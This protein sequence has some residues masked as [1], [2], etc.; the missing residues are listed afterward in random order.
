MQ[1]PKPNG[2]PVSAVCL[3]SPPI[4][5]AEARLGEPCQRLAFRVSAPLVRHALICVN[6]EEELL[7]VFSPW[8]SSR[9]QGLLTC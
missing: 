8:P 4:R 5:S 3:A 1:P 9:P 2:R 6:K 7:K